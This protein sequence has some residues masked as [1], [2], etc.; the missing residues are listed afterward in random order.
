MKNWREIQRSSFR[1]KE[2][3]KGDFL[4][5]KLGSTKEIAMYYR[6]SYKDKINHQGMLLKKRMNSKQNIW[7]SKSN[8]IN[9]S[10]QINKTN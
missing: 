10:K 4:M 8:T 3:M 2:K 1:I 7:K 5:S 9:C 6:K